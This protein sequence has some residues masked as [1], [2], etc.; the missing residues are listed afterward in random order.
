MIQEADH[1]EDQVSRKR[2]Q[3]SVYS[4]TSYRG[5]SLF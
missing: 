1:F 5:K 3:M 2:V 4:I